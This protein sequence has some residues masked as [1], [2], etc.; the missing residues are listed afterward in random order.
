M[1]K[2]ADATLAAANVALKT[3]ELSCAADSDAAPMPGHGLGA[4]RLASTSAA[5][6]R[7]DLAAL[8]ELAAALVSVDGVTEY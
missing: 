4:E 1:R 5:V 3:F 8:S 7:G 6:A 2:T